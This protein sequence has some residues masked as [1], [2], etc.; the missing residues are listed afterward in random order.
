MFVGPV[1][2]Q[3]AGVLLTLACLPAPAG[4]QRFGQRAPAPEPIVRLTPYDG[5]FV[6]AR[7]KYTTAPG[8]FYY[9]GLPAW[10]HGYPRA[11]NNLMRILGEVSEIKLHPD[12]SNVLALDDPELM[13]FPVSYMTEA[14][15]WTM[16]DKEATGLRGYLAKGGF[17]IFD[18]FRDN[19]GK[20]RKSVV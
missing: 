20:D 11:E 8:G 18:D 9:R 4:A 3:I 19:F 10:A 5:R 1:C 7:L 16:T 12:A 14:G 13:K 15:Y 17:V 6:F 2:R